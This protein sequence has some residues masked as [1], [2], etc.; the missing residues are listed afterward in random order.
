M[1]TE[2]VCYNQQI[3]SPTLPLHGTL[4]I[5]SPSLHAVIKCLV[6]V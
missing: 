1:H 2:L 3:Y 6:Y 4:A 5:I